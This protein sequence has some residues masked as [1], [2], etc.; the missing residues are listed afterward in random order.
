[1]KA[2]PVRHLKRR[3]VALNLTAI[4]AAVEDGTLTAADRKTI[5]RIL[6]GWAEKELP[7]TEGDDRRAL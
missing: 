2:K 7:P 4:L 5:E 3:R 6:P 1:M